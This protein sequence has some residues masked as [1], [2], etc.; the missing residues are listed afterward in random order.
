MTMKNARVFCAFAAML[1]VVALAAPS[2]VV[3]T[4]AG[5]YTLTVDAGTTN[6]ITA[7]DVTAA[8]GH[9][10]VKK[11]GGTL[12]SGADTSAFAGEI[13]IE[14]GI[15][16]VNDNGGLGTGA[17]GTVVSNG[18]A[19]Y[20]S[21][22]TDDA[23]RFAAGESLT[24][25]G[26]GP[27]GNGAFCTAAGS[28]QQR[29]LLYN[30]GTLTLSGDVRVGGPVD[31]AVGRGNVYLNGHTLTV[32]M[33]TPGGVIEVYDMACTAVASAG[34]IDLV[35]G[36]IFL[37]GSTTWAG[38]DSNVLYAR[39]GAQLAF[40]A[41]NNPVPWS[42]V[43]EDNTQLY[44]SS[45]AIWNSSRNTWSGP[46]EVQGTTLV[47][48]A[49]NNG[50]NTGVTLSGPVSGAGGFSIT[51]DTVLRLSC[52]NNSFS[53][54]VTLACNEGNLGGLILEATGALPPRESGNNTVNGGRVVLCGGDMDI[55]NFSFN[56]GVL[57]N[58]VAGTTVN[59][60]TLTKTGNRLF[61]LV[62][63]VAVTNG[64]DVKSP[65]LGT[66]A[67]GIRLVANMSGLSTCNF[68]SATTNFTPSKTEA[69]AEYRAFFGKL[70]SSMS[71]AEL[72]A[73]AEKLMDEMPNEVKN[74]PEL[75]YRAWAAEEAFNCTAYRGKFRLAG[76]ANETVT[77]GISI[78]DTAVVWVDGTLIVKNIGSYQL[79]SG[80]CFVKMGEA[81]LA[82]GD[83]ELLVLLGHYGSSG[84]GPRE[85]ATSQ[86]GVEWAADFGVGWH[87]GGIDYTA[88]TNSADF[89]AVTASTGNF[90]PRP[91]HEYSA[92]YFEGHRPS[93]AA[94]TVPAA[95][96]AIDLGDDLGIMPA[97]EVANLTGQPFVTNGAMKV[98]NVWTVIATDLAI[99]PL[100][101]AAG[102]GLDLSAATITVDNYA[103]LDRDE[104][105]VTI[106]EAADGA[107]IV[108]MPSLPPE[109]TRFWTVSRDTDASGVTRLKL[110]YRGGLRIIVR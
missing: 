1:G 110:V 107:T 26:E 5:T 3:D 98:T 65:S 55:P 63:G 62:G 97:Y 101:L 51:S 11:G 58:A 17:G 53:G 61:E 66:G 30:G 44:P 41:V 100:T 34:T 6:A 20:V 28:K 91:I 39:S 73:A 92:D 105:G 99:R 45:G 90:S 70:P 85:Q 14:E 80:T 71:N 81:V 49:G 35:R 40:R 64:L 22:A 72:K 43:L 96:G 15:L 59:I 24:I 36:R 13:R 87:T 38:D 29:R 8:S 69:Q 52:P 74:S 78:A 48:Y 54:G 67:A 56:R 104:G 108:G 46:V 102:A 109:R 2:G 25:C 21:Y 18:A 32:A 88:A 33:G 42:L 89:V 83:H 16:L 9:A 103:A 57:S 76:D 77:F 93:F 84:K 82:P 95:T 31:L 94:M 23:L 86:Y 68:I 60:G 50:G 37:D 7:D 47:E 106:A 4:D 75:A 10:L 27:D 12:V 19:L 79:T